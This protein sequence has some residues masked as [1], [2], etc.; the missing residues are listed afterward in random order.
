MQHSSSR[1]NIVAVF[2]MVLLLVAVI[3]ATSF[4]QERGRR[5]G[6]DFYQ[7][8]WRDSRRDKRNNGWRSHRWRGNSWNNGWRGNR[9]RASEGRW[10]QN[11]NAR[12]WNARSFDRRRWNRWDQNRRWTNRSDVRRS[13]DW[14]RNVR[15]WRN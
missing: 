3:P 5:G 14:S 7:V 8:D 13:R 10:W 1:R 9:G 6:R 11:S 15:R 4:G 12:W 2:V